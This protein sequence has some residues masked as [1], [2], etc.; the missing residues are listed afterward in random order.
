MKKDGIALRGVGATT[1]RAGGCT[2]SYKTFKI[3]NNP[4]FDI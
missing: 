2:L 4:L 3:D 1:L